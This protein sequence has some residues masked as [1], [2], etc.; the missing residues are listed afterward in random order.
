MAIMLLLTSCEP[1]EEPVIKDSKPYL[2]IPTDW[3]ITDTIRK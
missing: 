3:D 2:S 1:I